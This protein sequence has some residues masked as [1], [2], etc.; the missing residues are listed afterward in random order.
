MYIFKLYLPSLPTSSTINHQHHFQAERHFVVYIDITTLEQYITLLQ[1]CYC[2]FTRYQPCQAAMHHKAKL[3][4]IVVC[5]LQAKIIHS[6]T[7]LRT[8][9]SYNKENKP[10]IHR[11]T[12]LSDSLTGAITCV[13]FLNTSVS[14]TN[15][16]RH[17]NHCCKD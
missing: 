17:T 10:A 9:L 3:I 6:Q 16:F 8:F 2:I 11:I 5:Q 14:S 4:N 15:S 7:Y 1:S 12:Q 13:A